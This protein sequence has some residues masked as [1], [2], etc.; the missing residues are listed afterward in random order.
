MSSWF[1][2]FDDASCNVG[3][4]LGGHGT[5]RVPVNRQ[6]MKSWVNKIGMLPIITDFLEGRT[7]SSFSTETATEFCL[8]DFP[9]HYFLQT[10][11]LTSNNIG[12]LLPPFDLKQYT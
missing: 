5:G 1:A 2:H 6:E 10:R 7:V 3:E 11:R 8:R 9:S 12:G 4:V